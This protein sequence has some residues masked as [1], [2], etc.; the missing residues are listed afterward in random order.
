[1]QYGARQ[2]FGEIKNDLAIDPQTKIVLTPGWANGTDILARYFF[3][4]PLPFALGSVDSFIQ[5]M[6]DFDSSTTF[7]MLSNEYDDLIRSEKF[8][9]IQTKKMLPYP[10]GKPGFY[11]IQMRYVDNVEEIFRQEKIA[12]LELI[13]A[14]IFLQDGSLAGV[15]YSPLD[16]GMIKD[17]LD[18]DKQTIARSWEANPFQFIFDFQ[19]PRLINEIM[20][21]VGGE[22]TKIEV[23]LWISM[24]T[25]P[26]QFVLNL[27]ETPDPRQA[28][29]E[30]NLQQPV[31]KAEIQVYNVNE[32]EP[33]HV[34]VWE[35]RFLPDQ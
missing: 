33:A 11:F 16:M 2:I 31:I 27:E 9:D 21:F 5:N 26:V 19:E 18:G 14:D 24:N 29:V 30:V 10:D 32:S 7:V 4:D 34:H 13:G 8:T 22:P 23:D 28:L 3:P 12:R 25:A 6:L 20:L 17:V 35:I 1:M 15:H